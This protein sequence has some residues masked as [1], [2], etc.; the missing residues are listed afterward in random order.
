[1][2][3]DLYEKDEWSP[4]GRIELAPI[5][6]LVQNLKIGQKG[7]YGRLRKPKLEIADL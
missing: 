5:F 3:I 2:H 1:M 4:R 7:Y 6:E